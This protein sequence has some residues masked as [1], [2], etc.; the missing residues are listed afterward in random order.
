MPS[1]QVTMK[2]HNQITSAGVL[3]ET[4]CL[5]TKPDDDDKMTVESHEQVTST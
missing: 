3:T 2:S 1:S 4:K 5:M